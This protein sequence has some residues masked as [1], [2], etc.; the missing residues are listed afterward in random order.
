MSC[1]GSDGLVGVSGWLGFGP[2]DAL[3]FSVSLV[4]ECGE[5]VGDVDVS[6][7]GLPVLFALFFELG[8]GR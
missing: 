5:H 1:G 8:G 4:A 7:Y 3:F 6:G 2:E